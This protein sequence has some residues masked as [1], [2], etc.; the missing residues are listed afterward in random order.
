MKTKRKTVKRE[1]FIRAITTADDV[2]VKKFKNTKLAW[3][4]GKFIE[5]NSG[6]LKR[7]NKEVNKRTKELKQE[8]SAVRI[9]N[10]LEEKESGKLLLDAEK[11]YCYNKEGEKKVLQKEEEINEKIFEVVDKLLEEQVEVV[12]I[13]SELLSLPADLSNLQFRDLNTFVFNNKSE[14]EE[15]VEE[16]KETI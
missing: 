5:L 3:Y 14:F 10:A 13:T 9:E 12:C 16:E 11:N 2:A 6:V 4:A 8:L 7:H 15:D 1:D